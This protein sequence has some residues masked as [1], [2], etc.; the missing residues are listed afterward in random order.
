MTFP[1]WIPLGPW[2]VHPHLLFE[3]L[4]YI[5]GFAIFVARRQTRGDHVPNA[6]RWSLVTAAAIGAVIGSHVLNWIDASGFAGKTAVGGLLGAWIAVEIEKKRQHFTEPTGDLFALPLAIG[7]AIG[8][9]GCFLTGLPDG[10]YGV[11]TTLPW[12]VDLGDGI[13]RHPTAL[14]ES[15][16]MIVVAVALVRFE[17]SLPRGAAFKL[18]V[19]A[20][21]TFRLVVDIIKPGDPLAL[22]MT[23]IQWACVGGLAYYASRVAR[24]RA[25]HV[26]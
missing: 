17:R 16:F 20:Y 5:A 21:L 7:F 12:G 19:C 15:A 13:R 26:V 14:Y 1:V 18:F 10:T 24:A 22:H 9:I 11:Q 25:Y 6:V 8:R 4:A 23:A 2:R 3:S